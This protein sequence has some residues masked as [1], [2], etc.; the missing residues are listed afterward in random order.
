L[1]LSNNKLYKYG[2]QEIAEN[3]LAGKQNLV[4]LSIENNCIGNEGLKAISKSLMECRNI[5]EIYLY[6]NE[7][8]DDPIE[9]FTNLLSLQKNLYILAMEFN[10]IGYKGLAF[11]LN[12]LTDHKKLEKLFLNQNDINS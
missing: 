4:K 12:A 2:A 11:I 8:D 9:D 1:G 5:E 6:N 7:L 10:R 3:G